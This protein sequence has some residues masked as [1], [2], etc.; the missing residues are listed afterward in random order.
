MAKFE[1]KE[2]VCKE[3]GCTF[4]VPYGGMRRVYC[5]GRCAKRAEKRERG[6]TLN[7]RARRLLRKR[8][9]ELS[10]EIYV[11]IKPS[12]IYERDNWICGIC[13]EEI[14]RNAPHR[15]YLSASIDHVVPLARGGTHTPANVQ[16][17]HFGCNSKKGTR[18]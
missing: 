11:P 18:Q 14:D 2:L 8:F 15:S 6:G 17:A 16:A 3:C 7:H 13:G 12:H 10:S 5:G 1:E 9:G 4:T